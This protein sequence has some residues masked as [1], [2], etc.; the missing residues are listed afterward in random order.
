[1]GHASCGGKF[2]S[3][4]H[5]CSDLLGASTDL[6]G[7]LDQ[8]ETTE[9]HFTKVLWSNISNWTD[10]VK[11]RS[12]GFFRG[13]VISKIDALTIM[14]DGLKLQVSQGNGEPGIWV[15][16][17]PMWPMGTFMRRQLGRNGKNLAMLISIDPG[18]V[19]SIQKVNSDTFLIFQNVPAEAIKEIFIFDPRKNPATFPFVAIGR[20]QLKGVIGQ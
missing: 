6:M 16:D 12:P 14:R 5:L 2:C 18:R 11:K 9:D 1:M 13:M 20:D 3:Q 7:E 8:L 17:D 10:V 19:S 4:I 15:T